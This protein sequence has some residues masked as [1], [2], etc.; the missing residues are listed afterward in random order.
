MIMDDPILIAGGGIGGLITALALAKAGW[1]SHILESHEVFSEAGAGIELTP[2]AVRVLTKLGV[3]NYIRPSIFRPEEVQI[4]NGLTGKQ[5]KTYSFKNEIEERY[6]APYWV[7]HRADLQKALVASVRDFPNIQITCDFKVENIEQDS[8]KVKVSGPNKRYFSGP[9]LIGADGLWSTIRS[10]MFAHSRLKFTGQSASRGLI[11]TKDVPSPFNDS[12]I[13]IWLMPGAHL[14][15]YPVKAGNRINV[16]AVIEDDWREI[17]WNTESNPEELLFRFDSSATQLLELLQL[18]KGWRKWSL[19]EL[20][21]L[22][23]LSFENIALIGDAAHP[24]LPFL[25][26]GGAMAIEDATAITN[27]LVEANGEF[28][29]AWNIYQK[30]RR[31]RIARVQ[32][33]SRRNGQIYN[34]SAPQRWIRNLILRNYPNERLFD[35]FDWLFGYDQS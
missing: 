33:A 10:L 8:N 27:A 34:M 28:K 1:N 24:I 35:R 14:I 23:K 21:P 17:G 25:S 4:F 30:K 26:Q 5:L 19:Y 15:H 31:E 2:N 11:N 12:I 22:S 9:A 3:E 18:I 7:L 20:D 13:G 32:T 16:V 29:L 6:G